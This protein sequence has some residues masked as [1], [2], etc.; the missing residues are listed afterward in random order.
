MSGTTDHLVYSLKELKSASYESPTSARR[1][2][3]QADLVLELIFKL[4]SENTI[5][6]EVDKATLGPLIQ[7]SLKSI[8][9][10]VKRVAIEYRRRLDTDV[11]RKRSALQ[12][13]LEKFNDFPTRTP[14][15]KLSTELS[16]V[17]INES[18]QILD[19]L[20]SMWRNRGD[21]EDSE[22]DLD[23]GKDLP[24]SHVWWK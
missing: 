10:D 4:G 6:S 5:F 13:L 14:A 12:F 20:I 18:I 3:A 8:K 7:D 11:L 2:F 1:S 24:L 19:R 21:P 9:I 17:N 15:I 22:S 23:E 16:R